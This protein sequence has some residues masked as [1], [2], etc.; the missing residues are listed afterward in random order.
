VDLGQRWFTG[1]EEKEEDSR[2]EEK[3]ERGEKTGE[4]KFPLYVYLYFVFNSPLS[5]NP[6]QFSYF[7]VCE[8]TSN[9]LFYNTPFSVVSPFHELLCFP[10]PSLSI[11]LH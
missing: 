2:Y 8:L 5:S 9:Y 1:K 7:V 11:P 4:E 10:L 3:N 6:L